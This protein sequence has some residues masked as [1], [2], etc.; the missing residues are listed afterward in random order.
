MAF[1]AFAAGILL[2]FSASASSHSAIIRILGALA[3]IKGA[4]IFFN[5]ENLYTRSYNWYLESLSDQAH[6]FVGIIT[7]ILGTAVLSWII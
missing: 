7:V 4:F 1:L 3:M 2:V 5:P 6:R